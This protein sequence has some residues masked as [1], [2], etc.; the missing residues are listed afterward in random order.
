[1]FS[2]GVHSELSFSTDNHGILEF[3]ALHVTNLRSDTWDY[4]RCVVNTS[5]LF[6]LIQGKHTTVAEDA[7]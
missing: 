7:D 1:M 4:M 3:L 6:L 2:E 5:D